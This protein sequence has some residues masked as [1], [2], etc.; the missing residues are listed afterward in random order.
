MDPTSIIGNIFTVA[1]FIYAK[2]ELVLIKIAYKATCL[3]FERL[4]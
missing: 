4:K 3:P 1:K 2:A